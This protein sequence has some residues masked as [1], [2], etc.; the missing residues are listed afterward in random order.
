[1]GVLERHAS[2]LG[3]SVQSPNSSLV[4]LLK[5]L[6]CWLGDNFFRQSW[7]APLAYICSPSDTERFQHSKE[8][9]NI[10]FSLL[11]N[12]DK[13]RKGYGVNK[14]VPLHPL[15]LKVS[16]FLSE[17]VLISQH[18]NVSA[19]ILQFSPFTSEMTKAAHVEVLSLFRC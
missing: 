12:D 11:F 10:C 2:A 5:S 15:Q 18:K 17:N 4:S 3:F 9:Q 8:T 16:L 13:S 19:I 6:P 14:S 1:M 7:L